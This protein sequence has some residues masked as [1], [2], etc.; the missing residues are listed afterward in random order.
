M[1]F[2]DK[3]IQLRKQ[4]G[5]SQEE[6]AEKLGV[7]RQAV[8]KWEGAQS[9][10]DLERVLK[11]ADLFGVTTDYLLRDDAEAPEYT[12]V[13]EDA[14]T[15]RRV[16]MEE[17]NAFLSVKALTADR[18]AWATLLCI[19]SPICLLM[20]AA[21]ADVG[22][23]SENFAGGVGLIVLFLMVAAAVAVYI[24]CGMR[25][26]PYEY[27]EKQVIE[28]EYGVSGMVRERQQRY[29][30]TYTKAIVVGACLCILSVIPLFTAAFIT[31]N[32]LWL[33]GSLSLQLTLAGVGV[34]CFIRV[35][36][37]WVSMQK[38]LQEEDY[39]LEAKKKPPPC[40]RY[41]GCVLVGGGGNF[42]WV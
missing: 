15:V 42:P 26:K 29:R 18:I 24:T 7:S 27:L 41:C 28:T 8:S 12:A 39:T 25:T 20:L 13:D 2:A 9:T 34:W 33:M 32:T 10:P 37:R 17:A 19:F 5:W 1:I 40:W 6:L 31:E 22:R 35:G 23:I 14:P 21:A 3:L 36:I 30:D 4:L 16:S 38:L 11:L